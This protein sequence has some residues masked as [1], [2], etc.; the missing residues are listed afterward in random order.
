MGWVCN[1][2]EGHNIAHRIFVMQ[3]LGDIGLEGRE[4]DL[5]TALMDCR[6]R[7]NVVKLADVAGYVAAMVVAWS[8]LCCE[9]GNWMDLAVVKMTVGWNWLCCKDGSRMELP[10][11]LNGSRIELAVL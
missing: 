1:W 11:L 9:D 2:V 7:D 8:R 10:V 4:G 6:E 3:P 5:R